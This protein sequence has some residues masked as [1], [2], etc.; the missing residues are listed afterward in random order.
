MWWFGS[1]FNLQKK[2]LHIIIRFKREEFV[3]FAGKKLDFLQK[4]SKMSFLGWGLCD[5]VSREEACGIG[6][7]GGAIGKPR[8][9]RWSAGDGAIWFELALE[10]HPEGEKYKV[11]FG[12][13]VNLKTTLLLLFPTCFGRL[14]VLG[15]APALPQNLRVACQPL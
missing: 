15:L 4:F 2:A 12:L 9:C 1:P 5:G 3:F 10:P 13:K 14:L 6:L 7:R 11:E 8:R